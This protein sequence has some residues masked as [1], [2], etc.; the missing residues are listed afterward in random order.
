MGRRPKPR[1]IPGAKPWQPGESGNPNRPISGPQLRALAATFGQA[2]ILTLGELL[3][4]A[5]V[6]VRVRAAE[7]LL[8][9]GFGRPKSEVTIHESADPLGIAQLRSA[10]RELLADATLRVGLREALRASGGSANGMSQNA[11]LTLPPESGALPPD[12]GDAPSQEDV[13]ICI[14]SYNADD[15]A[16]SPQ[17]VDKPV[18]NSPIVSDYL[19]EWWLDILSRYPRVA[20]AGG[21]RT[22]KT[23]LSGIGDGRAVVHTDDWIDKTEW[24]G[25]PTE[26]IKAC[27][28]GPVIVEGVQVPRALRKGLS[29]DC[30]VWCERPRAL[31][32][33]KQLIMLAG[34]RTI[35]AEWA[36][37]DAGSTPVFTPPEDA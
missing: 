37:K 25:V 10:A 3:G 5:K 29:V 8:D 23:T 9:R 32:T 1:V 24:E 35:F 13:T 2:A 7:A 28:S 26:V 16:E 33:R 12:S 19:R 20:I 36:S 31:Q 21:P 17:A 6:E 34:L 22:G 4:H 18:D 30:V 15:G 11:T 14:K 27:G